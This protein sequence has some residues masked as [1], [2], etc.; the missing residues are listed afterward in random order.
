[1]YGWHKSL[2]FNSFASGNTGVKSDA[3]DSLVIDW[4]YCWLQEETNEILH[5][6]Y[7]LEAVR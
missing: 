7:W 4:T 5:A 3:Y 6:Q 1:M 2:V